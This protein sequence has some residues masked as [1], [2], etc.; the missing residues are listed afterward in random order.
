[1]TVKKILAEIGC[2]RLSLMCER[3]ANIVRWKF[4]YND[5]ELGPITRYTNAGLLSDLSFD[6]WVELGKNFVKEIRANRRT[7]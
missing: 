3:R 2:N 4:V 5:R 7:R 1:M 6:G